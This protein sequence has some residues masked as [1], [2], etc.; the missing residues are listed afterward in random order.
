MAQNVEVGLTSRAEKKRYISAI[1]DVSGSIAGRQLPRRNFRLEYYILN[2]LGKTFSREFIKTPFFTNSEYKNGN[3]TVI[4]TVYFHW[5]ISITH[6]KA[7]KKMVLYYW[8]SLRLVQN[9]EH[10]TNKS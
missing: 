9:T 8:R 4:F 7:Y 6:R 3:V 2:L 5:K 10:L 1:S